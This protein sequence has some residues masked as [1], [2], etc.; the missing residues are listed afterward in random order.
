M[1]RSLLFITLLAFCAISM[2]ACKEDNAYVYPQMEKAEVQLVDN[3]TFGKVVTDKDGRTL[4]FFSRDTKRGS[5]CEGGCLAAWP[6]F[7]SENITVSQGLNA[8]DFTT[9]TRADGAKQTL[10][11]GFPL[12]HF[13]QDA[14]A[15]QTKGEGIDGEWFV[16]KPDYSV[17][18]AKAQ[19]VGADTKSYKANYTLENYV[20]GTEET[21][22]LT[23]PNGRT[24]Y[25]FRNDKNGI[26]NYGGDAAVWPVYS[27]DF[28]KLVVPSILKT[29]DFGEITKD[30]H[31]Q[32]TY[33]GWPLYYFGGNASIL[34]DLQP[35]DNRGVSVVMP[36]V[37]RVANTSTI[38]A[39]N[40][41][42]P[43]ILTS[44]NETFGNILTDENG[45]TLYFFS[46]DTKGTSVCLGGCADVWPAF[47]SETIVVS[48]GL[49]TADFTSITRSD[50]AK[51]TVYKGYPLYHYSQD[52]QAGEIKGDGI[53]DIWFVAK[54]DYSLFY[55]K[56]QLVGADTKSYVANYTL[57]NYTEGIE[58]TFY[59]TDGKGR[60][61]YTFRNDQNGINN[62][63]GD[64]A[65]WP[66]FYTEAITL[67]LPSVLDKADFAETTKD[68]IKQ[69]T[70]KGW[71]L[72]Y[73]GG[74]Q[75][76][77]GDTNKGDTRGVSVVSP[78]VW[79]I[80]NTATS[81]APN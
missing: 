59:L 51:Q 32:L 66:V 11:K 44:E 19:L 46:R 48:G 35:G 34:G 78:G 56:G 31:K 65:V 70:Y 49:N 76:I 24:L 38:I 41:P 50:G 6:A 57:A 28:G 1:Q 17:F 33:K 40:P 42:S 7:F 37:W 75:A 10:Y 26:N 30:G 54:P 9:L 61:L 16:A 12:Y 71:P 23:D 80:T 4:Y 14:Q 53:T 27:V 74:N 2:V 52:V 3:S 55:A 15:G 25:T 45:R 13:A 47:Y 67:Q 36:G 39:P 22:Y 64:L 68:G 18:Y 8:S 79:P 73:F 20:E 81:V 60:T 5:V 69:L 62:Y 21:F 29:S 43:T 72:H 58:E 77:T 63:S